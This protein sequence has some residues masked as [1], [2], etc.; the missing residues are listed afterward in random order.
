MAFPMA[1]YRRSTRW[2][3]T[4]CIFCVRHRTVP[5]VNIARRDKT[6]TD[7]RENVRENAEYAD[8]F[9]RYAALRR[10]KSTNIKTHP[11]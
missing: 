3:N 10:V 4:C 11:Q 7:A 2:M 8:V 1:G 5:T 9:M 6:R